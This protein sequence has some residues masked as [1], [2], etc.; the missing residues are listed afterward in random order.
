MMKALLLAL[1]VCLAAALP[2]L[3]APAGNAPALGIGTLTGH[4]WFVNLSPGARDE[5][6]FFAIDPVDANSLYVRRFATPSFYLDSLS[7]MDLKVLLW[8]DAK[9]LSLSF[10]PDGT[11]FTREKSPIKVEYKRSA[12]S[13]T[14]ARGALS[15]YEG[16]WGI[17]DPIMTASIRA[18]EKRTWALVMYFP[19]DPLSAI[20]LGYYPLSPSGDGSYRSSSAFADSFI[21]IEYDQV[22]DALVIRPLFKDRPLAPELYDPVHAWRGK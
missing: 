20:P 21:E 16:D 12:D 8:P 5:L 11:S 7:G 4:S 6:R 22:S 1:A 17:G 3:A 13:S 18:C 2:A 15:P 19:G 9:K 14:A 10:A